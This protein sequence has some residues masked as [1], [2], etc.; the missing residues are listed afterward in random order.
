MIDSFYKLNYNGNDLDTF[1]MFL[2]PTQETEYNL[3]YMDKKE[4]TTAQ[5][6]ATIEEAKDFIEK[7]NEQTHPLYSCA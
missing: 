3:L 5:E 4:H 7:E 1:Q 2:F 6:Q